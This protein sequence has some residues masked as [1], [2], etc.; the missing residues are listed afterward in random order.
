MKRT[1]DKRAKFKIL[2]ERRVNNAINQIRLIGNLSRKNS[3]KYEE[4][5]INKMKKAINNELN[6]TWSKFNSNS[7]SSETDKFTL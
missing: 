4:A 6:K 1:E 7:E 3:Y 2:A 5:D